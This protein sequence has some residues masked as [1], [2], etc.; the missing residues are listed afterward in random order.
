M[1]VAGL[2]LLV[3]F[4]QIDRL[5]E[6]GN[7]EQEKLRYVEAG[8]KYNEAA[9]R[10]SLIGNVQTKALAMHNLATSQYRLGQYEAAEQNYRDSIAIWEAIGREGDLALALNNFAELRQARGDVAEALELSTR[11]VAL[12]NDPHGNRP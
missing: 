7:R 6:A 1:F 2:V 10:A 4:H 12:D 9:R 11:S 8:E 3:H 5:V